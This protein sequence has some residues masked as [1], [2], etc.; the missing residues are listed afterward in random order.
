MRCILMWGQLCAA[1]LCGDNYVLHTY[2]GTAYLCA[3]YLCGD[4]YAL[5]TYVGTIMRCK[6]MWGQYLSTISSLHNIINPPKKEINPPWTA[7]LLSSM[8]MWRGKK[9]NNNKNNKTT[10][11]AKKNNNKKQKTKPPFTHISPHRLQLSVYNYTY[12]VTPTVFS[13][14]C[15]TTHTGWPPQCS[16]QKR[17]NNTNNINNSKHNK[18]RYN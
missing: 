14:Q 8:S 16:A 13:C 1:C 15:T 17:F 4:N 7:I 10:T 9:N 6:L 12:R 18:R 11:T 5:H 2:V 3:A